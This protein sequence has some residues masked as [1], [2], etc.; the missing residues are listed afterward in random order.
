MQVMGL[1]PHN[2]GLTPFDFKSPEYILV[3]T[4]PDK[5]GLTIILKGGKR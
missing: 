1:P 2:K 3:E 5:A 4:K